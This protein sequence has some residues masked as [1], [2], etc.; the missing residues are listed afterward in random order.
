M[1][2][3]HKDP[4]REAGSST[5]FQT[6][7]KHCHTKLLV[8]PLTTLESLL[9]LGKV[10]ASKSGPD[11]P[12]QPYSLPLLSLLPGHTTINSLVSE[13]TN[14][15]AFKSLPVNPS[16]NSQSFFHTLFLHLLLLDRIS[17]SPIPYAA[18]IYHTVRYLFISKSPPHPILC[19]PRLCL[20]Y[21]CTLRV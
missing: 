15:L 7:Q 10:Q 13:H 12:F 16:V 18:L 2:Q 19:C 5:A 21:L 3:G 17:H 8:F 4:P 9:P 14:L 11:L 1:E 6:P 20:V